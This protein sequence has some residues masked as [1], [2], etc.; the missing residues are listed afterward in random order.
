MTHRSASSMQ[1]VLN[2][3]KKANM[4]QVNILCFYAG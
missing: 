4:G 2:R 1:C 3:P